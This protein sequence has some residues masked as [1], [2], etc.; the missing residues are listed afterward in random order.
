M[1]AIRTVWLASCSP[2]YYLFISVGF[3]EAPG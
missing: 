1:M 2:A 3:H